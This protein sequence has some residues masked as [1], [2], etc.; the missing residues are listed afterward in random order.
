MRTL[1]RLIGSTATLL[2]PFAFACV[3]EQASD[4][5]NVAPDGGAD[6]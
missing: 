6:A 3:G 1:P 5:T 2:V 4:P